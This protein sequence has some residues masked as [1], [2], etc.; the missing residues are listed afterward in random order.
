MLVA[1]ITDQLV[2]LDPSR[3][4]S[5]QLVEGGATLASRGV[6]RR[7]LRVTD[8]GW[9]NGNRSCQAGMTQELIVDEGSS[10]P[11]FDGMFNGAD[12]WQDGMNALSLLRRT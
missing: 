3:D 11:P 12:G 8:N 7:P 2:A 9:F 1:I 5:L 10:W 4:D 6:D